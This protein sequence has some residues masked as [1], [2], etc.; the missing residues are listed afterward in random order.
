MNGDPAHM[1]GST[2]EV[3]FVYVVDDIADDRTLA[4]QAVVSAGLQAELFD[5][6]QAFLDAL[7]GLAPGIVLLDVMMP[8]V[9]GTAVL[10]KIGKNAPGFVVIMMSA[11]ADVAI[12]V[13]AMRRG[14]HDFLLKPLAGTETGS[15]LERA[16]ALLDSAEQDAGDRAE[17]K[18]L[19]T[20]ITPRE[21]AVLRM[22]LAGKRNKMIA[23]E[24][25]VSERTVEVHRSRLI[26]RTKAGTFAGL[27]AFAVK[28]G[29]EPADY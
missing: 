6:G 19:L 1:E 24:L 5:G 21:M 16:V 17:I 13:K 26:G 7:S 8:G 29:V 18:S 25:G 28:A 22:L 12:A 3:R 15:T 14:A 4:A 20:A 9:D 23:F 27:I 2:G 10:E 11:H